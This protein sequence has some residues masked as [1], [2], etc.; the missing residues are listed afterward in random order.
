M[1]QVYNTLKKTKEE[2]QTIRPGEVGIYL[3]GPTVYKPSHIGHMV[4]PVIFDCITRYLK[5][6]GYAVRFVVNITDVDDKL[7]AESRARGISMSALAEEMTK[8]YQ[9]NLAALGVDTITDFPKATDYIH[10]IIQFIE[11]LVAQDFAYSA[12]GDVYFDISRFNEYGKL[13]G[14]SPDQMLGEGGMT[15]SR[16]RNIAD[17]ALWKSA[18]EGEPF[19]E[20]PWGPG[21]PGWHIECSVMS[22]ALLGDTFD[23]H[24]G[25]LDL[26]FPHHENEIAQSECCTGKSY[27]KYWMHNG[28]MQAS[29]EVGKVGGRKTR[30]AQN[31]GNDEPE[32]GNLASQEAGKI[33]K[34]KGAS[35]FREMLEEFS[36]EV[37]RFFVLSSHYR[38]PIDFST[39]RIRQVEV[40]METFYRFIKRFQ[41][42][43]GESFY[44]LDFPENR[45]EGDSLARQLPGGF[46]EEVLKR[47]EKYLQSM[48][49]DFNTAGAIGELFELVRTLNRFVDEY[50]LESLNVNYLE[51]FGKEKVVL[52]NELKNG[53]RV[54][55]EL[56][57]TLGMFRT[58]VV[59]EK[60]STE[61]E[62]LT[63]DLMR[64]LIDLRTAAKKSKDFVTAD[65]IRNRLREIGIAL[66]DRPGGTEWNKLN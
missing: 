50:D 46:M 10:Q 60:E 43:T 22:Q 24:G 59:S 19:W 28:L 48:D 45:A 17:F 16:K 11:K 38:R 18:K 2:F 39:E 30:D 35:A 12:E 52:I 41:Q 53:C 61:D 56:A 57:A 29:S 36:G 5:Y 25:G 6:N 31:A 66:E 21:R 3:C 9:A 33:S 54:F 27:V 13:S 8:D 32:V 4:G 44:E 20:S 40:G 55:R 34:S 1:I 49:D 64:I 58:E 37:I 62:H 51:R 14:R 47:R 7:I 15:A 42:I 23:I 65:M 63:A 26:V